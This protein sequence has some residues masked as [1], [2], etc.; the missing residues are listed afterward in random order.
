[1]WRND[2]TI[3]IGRHQNPWRECDLARMEA[4]GVELSRR[5]SGGGAVYQ[6][7]RQT[8]RSRRD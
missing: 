5:D 6:V 7:G 4:D 1:M 3:V 8:L 2:K